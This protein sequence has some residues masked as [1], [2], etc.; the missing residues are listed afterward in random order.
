M[1]IAR[2]AD[3]NTETRFP[4]SSCLS[5]RRRRPATLQQS[6][7][8]SASLAPPAERAPR[9]RPSR[10]GWMGFRRR[11]TSLTERPSRLSSIRYDQRKEQEDLRIR[12]S[13]R[14]PLRLDGRRAARSRVEDTQ[15][16]EELDKTTQ[17]TACVLAL[18]RSIRRSSAGSSTPSNGGRQEVGMYTKT[19]RRTVRRGRIVARP[20]VPWSFGLQRKIAAAAT[21]GVI[22]GFSLKMRHLHE[23]ANC[24]HDARSCN[25]L[26]ARAEFVG[27]VLDSEQREESP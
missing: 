5:R 13:L 20:M 27:K 22:C 24:G 17:A 16:R 12:S 18:A 14:S 2:F 7:Y 15:K 3:S 11:Q 4:S 25:L 6:L 19:T 23:N 21:A 10:P 8:C 9:L 26:A 1:R